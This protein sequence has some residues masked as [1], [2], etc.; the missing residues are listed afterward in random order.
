M[1]KQEL[2]LDATSKLVVDRHTCLHVL[3]WW[4]RVLRSSCS[5]FSSNVYRAVVPVAKCK[6]TI[7]AAAARERKSRACLT[8]LQFF[9][10]R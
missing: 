6:D 8:G 2:H 10:R 5:S 4:A 9:C 7:P 1:Q 3:A